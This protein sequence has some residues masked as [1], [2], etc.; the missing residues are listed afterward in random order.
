MNPELSLTILVLVSVILMIW[1]TLSWLS[2]RKKSINFS[3]NY[4]ISLGPSIFALLILIVIMIMEPYNNPVGLHLT[5]LGIV[6]PA[7]CEFIS[8]IYLLVLTIKKKKVMKITDGELFI[9]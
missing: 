1:A 7:M 8:F 6:I 2:Y 4:L 5:T 9:S 3:K